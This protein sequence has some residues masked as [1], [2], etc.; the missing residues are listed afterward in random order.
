[1]N[2][3]NNF[4]TDR[5]KKL[6]L[7]PPCKQIPQEFKNYVFRKTRVENLKYFNLEYS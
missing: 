4:A 5:P 3:E 6:A 7:F 2:K 1:M